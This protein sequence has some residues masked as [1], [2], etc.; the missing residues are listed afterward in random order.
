[1]RS[2]FLR[3]RRLCLFIFIRRFFLTLDICIT[4]SSPAIAKDHALLACTAG[5][6]SAIN[7]GSSGALNKSGSRSGSSS[8]ALN[9]TCSRGAAASC[10]KIVLFV[11]NRA[12]VARNIG[13]AADTP[14]RANGRRERQRDSSI[15]DESSSVSMLVSTASPAERVSSL[16]T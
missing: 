9:K 4:S 3:F 16:A 14:E 5:V 11:E 12:G 2:L 6:A 7:G 1:M 15:G 10:C 8:G 13:A